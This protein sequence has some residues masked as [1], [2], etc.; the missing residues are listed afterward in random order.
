MVVPLPHLEARH[1]SWTFSCSFL[2]RPTILRHIPAALVGSPERSPER[3]PEGSASLPRLPQAAASSSSS[4]SRSSS[5]SPSSNVTWKR[6]RSWR[7]TPPQS[8]AASPLSDPPS[9]S[10]RAKDTPTGQGM[11]PR[12][13]RAP[14]TSRTSWTSWTPSPQGHG[15][16]HETP[17]GSHRA[18]TQW[19]TPSKGAI[20][21]RERCVCSMGLLM[22]S[23]L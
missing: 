12:S 7:D 3:S 23:F 2:H 13:P 17:T 16:L 4:S 20:T 10:C 21:T 22:R 14:R 18:P 19:P 6:I 11:T 5:P 9:S 1:H 15:V 8:S